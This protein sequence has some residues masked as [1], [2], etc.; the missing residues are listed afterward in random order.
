MFQV[1]HTFL[2][3][4]VFRIDPIADSDDILDR[5]VYQHSN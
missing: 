3:A 4:D 2:T 1:T 5:T